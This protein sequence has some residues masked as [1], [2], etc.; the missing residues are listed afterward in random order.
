MKYAGELKP[1]WTDISWKEIPE[2]KAE[3]NPREKW[4]QGERLYTI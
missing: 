4:G 1:M 2:V 3:Y